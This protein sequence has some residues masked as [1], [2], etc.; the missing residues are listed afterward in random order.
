MPSNTEQKAV[1]LGQL[2]MAYEAGALL[3]VNIA[4]LTPSSTFVKNNVMGINGVL[5]RATQATQNLPCT[6]VSENGAFVVNT[7]NGKTAFTVTDPTPN[8]GWEIWSDAS[9]EYWISQLNALIAAK[10]SVSDVM[11][12]TVNYGNATFTVSQLLTEMAKLMSKTVV[13]Q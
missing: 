10:A 4:T 11:A 9:I 13:T 5:Y 2:K 6:M 3:P 12:A 8:A 1:N 7:I